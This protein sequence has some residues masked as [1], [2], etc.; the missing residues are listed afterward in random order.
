MSITANVQAL[1]A[2][3][4]TAE[5]RF[6]ADGVLNSVGEAV[7]E[8][9]LANDYLDWSTGT[10]DLLGITDTGMMM[11]NRNWEALLVPGSVNSRG[12]ALAESEQTDDGTG[13]PYQIQ[14]ALSGGHL[15]DGQDVWLED[16]GRWFANPETGRP[17]RA[18]GVIRIVT[19]RRKRE[20]RVDRMSRFDPLTGLLNRARLT[21]ELDTLFSTLV[22]D[23]KPASFILLG[24]EHFDL[25]N[26]VYGF[27]AGDAVMS[28]A[29]RRITAN[30][31]ATDIVGRFSGA[32]I[33]VVLP[34][35]DDQ[36]MLIAGYRMLNVLRNEPIITDC[37][38][39]ALTISIGG[40]SIPQHARECRTAFMAANQALEESRRNRDNVVA[41]YRPDPERERLRLEAGIMAEN[42][43]NALREGR[44]HLVWQPIV[45]AE[46]GEVAFHEALVRLEEH[47]GT[48]IEAGDFVAIAERL[49]LI[50]LVDH[51]ALDLALETMK[52]CST[53]TF[54][55]NVSNETAC[56][57]EWLSKVA[58]AIHECPDIAKRLI[59]E[60]T[61]SHAAESDDEARR[62]INSLADLGCRVAL[63][64]FGAGYTSFRTLKA[65][66]FDVIKI[67]GQFAVDLEHSVENQ[68]FIQSLVKLASLYGARTVVE[69][70]EDD[71]T[72]KMLRE[73]GVDY[74]QGFAYGRPRKLL[75][76]PIDRPAEEAAVP[77]IIEEI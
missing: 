39:I 38:S 24:L 1:H 52:R 43:I 31:R 25:V 13:V 53:A 46:T 69:W 42:I 45:D 12:A 63:D 40:V 44:I 64:D 9:N 49:G 59:V 72:A 65:L 20:E 70:V 28:E 35:C 34:E 48:S 17:A 61:E 33:G 4:Q 41:V 19:E 15:R 27:E 71:E 76:W 73:W 30:L 11:T 18:H 16:T 8:W 7:Y 23:G 6:S 54:S 51:H 66:P 21:V 22:D 62:F 26:Q 57:P 77:E 67:D 36:D 37:G 47:D 74:L 2:Q 10:S 50:R 56:D 68:T 32:K 5:R 14:Y 29:A 75:P 60:I 58:H 3:P 55:L